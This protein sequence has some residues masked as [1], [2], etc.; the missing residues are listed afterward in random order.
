MMSDLI[1]KREILQTLTLV[2]GDW[3]T[4]KNKSEDKEI[5]VDGLFYLRKLKNDKTLKNECV[6]YRTRLS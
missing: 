1:S 6:T 2:Q 4:K 3:E 5:T